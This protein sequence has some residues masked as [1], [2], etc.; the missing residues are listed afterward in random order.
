VSVA[1]IVAHR[2]DRAK[3]DSVTVGEFSN[4]IQRG[5]A[6]LKITNA[7]I[8]TTQFFLAVNVFGVL[9]TITL[10]GGFS[11]SLYNI[12]ASKPDVVQLFMQG[13]EARRRDVR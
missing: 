7:P 8:Q 6:L 9:R 4:H 5:Q 13:G 12:A 11:Q 2:Y 1:G 10:G 3:I